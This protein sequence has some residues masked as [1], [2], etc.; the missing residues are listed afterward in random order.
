MIELYNKALHRVKDMLCN[1]SLSDYSLGAPEFEKYLLGDSQHEKRQFH[2]APA[3]WGS[4][5][6]YAVISKVLTNV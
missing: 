1:S 5:E 2:I 6:Y 4:P 3:Y